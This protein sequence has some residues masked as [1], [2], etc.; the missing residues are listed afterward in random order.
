MLQCKTIIKVQTEN[1]ERII[2][3]FTLKNI[4]KEIIFQHG[5]S[6]NCNNTYSSV[7][8]IVWFHPHSGDRTVT[9]GWCKAPKYVPQ[10]NIIRMTKSRKMGWAGH[11]AQIGEMRNA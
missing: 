7:M 4:M 10:P 9:E 3:L 5:K 6:F 8:D 2:K 1:A 11:I